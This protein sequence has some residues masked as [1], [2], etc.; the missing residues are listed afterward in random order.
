MLTVTTKFGGE[1]RTFGFDLNEIEEI[2]RIVEPGKSV[3]LGV[4]IAR[5]MDNDFFFQDVYHT[6]RLGLIGGGECSPTR[7]KELVDT[8]IVGKPLSPPGDPSAPLNVAKVILGNIM[9]GVAENDEPKKEQGGAMTG[10]ST[11]PQSE[12]P[13][14]D[15]ASAL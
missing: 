14:S 3:G 15:P 4:I 12:Q 10:T 5:V 7:A 8:Y 2:Q 11:S 13:L 1:D 6:I 9:W